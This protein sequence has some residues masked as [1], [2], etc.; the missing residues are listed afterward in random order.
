[1]RVRIKAL[2]NTQVE[3]SMIKSLDPSLSCYIFLNMQ[4][5]FKCFLPIKYSE[6]Y[7][8]RKRKQYMLP[9]IF[10]IFKKDLFVY[11]FI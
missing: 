6:L 11:L 3:N 1:M 8:K 5:V 2:S 4:V 9:F 10:F 7:L